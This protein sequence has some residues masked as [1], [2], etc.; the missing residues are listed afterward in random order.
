MMS[1]NIRNWNELLANKVVLL[2]S[3]AGS[4][5][6]YI[7]RACYAHGARLVLGDLDLEKT[8]KVKDEILEN[9]NNNE[10]RILVVELDV[11]NE[12]T[13]YVLGNVEQVSDE[14]WSRV[15]DV[16]V[17]GYALMAKY[18]APIF[19]KQNSG[20]IVNMGSISGL[21]A[22]PNWIPYSATKGA[23]IQLTRNLVLDLGS[24]NIRVNSVS[25]SG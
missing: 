19:K 6:R 25:P 14:N 22:S 17:R 24:F 21:I 18:I 9:E 5:A 1:S 11:T 16:N 15:F 10:D 4:V 20:S 8:N 3:A 13:T 7:A 12:T 2:T 23:I